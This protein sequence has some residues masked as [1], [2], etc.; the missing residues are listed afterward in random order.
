LRSE[1][2]GFQPFQTINKTEDNLAEAGK[3]FSNRYFQISSR[4]IYHAPFGPISVAI[5]Y[6][7]RAEELWFFNVSLGYYLFNNRPF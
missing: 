7:D 6:F 1:M 3:Q 5:D 2:Y 4:V